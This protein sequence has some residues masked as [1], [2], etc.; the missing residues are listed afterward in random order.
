MHSRARRL[1]VSTALL[2]IVAV[3]TAFG[4]VGTAE[5][6]TISQWAM[7]G[8]YRWGW[9]NTDP[10]DRYG[11][12][13]AHQYGFGTCTWGAAYLARHNAYGLGGARYWTYNASRHGLRT[14]TIARLNATAVFQPGVQ[15]AGGGGHV[16]HVVQVIN[17]YW[18]VVRDMNF[19]WNGGGWNRWSYRY[20]HVG[21][22]V[23]FI[24]ATW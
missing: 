20:A 12:Q 9:V 13:A 14:G 4:S 17:S 16:A 1:A 7:P 10:A 22:G 18:F 2:T 23:S 24:Y 8:G 19:Y 15:G 3:F 11:N 5:A 21:P 6:A